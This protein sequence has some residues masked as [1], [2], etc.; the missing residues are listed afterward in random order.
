MSDSV[1]PH[2]RQPTRH[3]HPWDSP[4]KNTEVGCHCLQ[5]AGGIKPSPPKSLGPYW[6]PIPLG[7]AGIMNCISNVLSVL[8]GVFHDSGFHNRATRSEP[9]FFSHYKAAGRT[10][11]ERS[12][13]PH[14][15]TWSQMNGFSP[16]YPTQVTATSFPQSQPRGFPEES[17]KE[18]PQRV[19]FYEMLFYTL[20]NSMWIQVILS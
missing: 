7:P 1:Q 11:G 6:E 8:R 2:R 17:L 13:P 14:T 5:V 12:R 10:E 9:F 20:W 15:H 18:L 19:C 3:P 4:S 16:S